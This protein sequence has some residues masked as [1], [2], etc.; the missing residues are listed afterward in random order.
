MTWDA[1]TVRLPRGQ[2]KAETKRLMRRA[3]DDLRVTCRR[4]AGGHE[5][6]PL[7]VQRWLLDDAEYHWPVWSLADPA[8]VPERLFERVVADLRTLRAAQAAVAPVACAAATT[9]WFARVGDAI[10]ALARA[11]GGGWRSPEEKAA[12]R[13]LLAEL[14]AQS[15]AVRRAL[16]AEDDAGRGHAPAP[17]AAAR[18]GG[19]R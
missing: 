2:L 8:A 17:L 11:S 5:V 16:D 19:A 13:R 9:T 1:I 18:T 7:V 12:A 14:D 15:L 3:L 4:V 6:T 10:G